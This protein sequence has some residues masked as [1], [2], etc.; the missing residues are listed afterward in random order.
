V[1]QLDGH[2]QLARLEYVPS[3]AAEELAQWHGTA[4]RRGAHVR[5]SVERDERRERVPGR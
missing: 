5:D 2:E 3:R 4:A 1:R